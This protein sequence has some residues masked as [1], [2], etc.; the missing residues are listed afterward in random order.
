V[1]KALRLA[2]GDVTRVCREQHPEVWKRWRA[3]GGAVSL[4][5]LA[6][7]TR[8]G[9]PAGRIALVAVLDGV[10]GAAIFPDETAAPLVALPANIAGL[11]WRFRCPRL[12]HRCAA[13]FKPDGAGEFLSRQAHGLAYRSLSERPAERAARKARKLRARLGEAPAV[14]GGPLPDKPLRMRW[15]TYERLCDA[16]QEAE[17]RALSASARMLAR[18]ATGAVAP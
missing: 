14:L 10:Q 11:L 7:L 1:E 16:I 8:N 6:P 13:L 3:T 12:G 2:A 18:M 15:P 9:A 5:V 4:P 17:D